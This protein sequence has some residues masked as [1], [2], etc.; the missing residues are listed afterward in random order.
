VADFDIWLDAQFIG[1]EE[2]AGAR[3]MDVEKRDH[4]DLGGKFKSDVVRKAN[5]HSFLEPLNLS[6]RDNPRLRRKR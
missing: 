5:Q 1:L 6:I 2:I 4:G 3:G